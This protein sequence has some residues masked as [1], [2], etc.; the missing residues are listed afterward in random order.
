MA[1]KKVRNRVD[2]PFTEGLRYPHRDEGDGQGAGESE[3]TSICEDT[4]SEF[5]LVAQYLF[6]ENSEAEVADVF[7]FLRVKDMGGLEYSPGLMKRVT[8]EVVTECGPF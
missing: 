6:R 4:W 7:E 1:G 3:G 5:I 8:R 2:I